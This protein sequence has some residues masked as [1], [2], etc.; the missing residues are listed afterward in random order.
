MGKNRRHNKS[1]NKLGKRSQKD[2]RGEW[3]E[4]ERE[5]EKWEN[6]YRNQNLIS[7]EEWPAFKKACQ[8]NLPLTFRI[9]GSNKHASEIGEIF[10]NKHIPVL[11]KIE[12]AEDYSPPKTFS[13]YPNN[14]GFQV[15]LPKSVVKKNVNFASTQRFLVSETEVGNISRQEAVSMIPPLVL[16]VEPHHFVLDMCAAP[17]SKTAQLVEA[18]HANDDKE[19]PT[20]FVMAN[21]S[22]YRRSHMLV[23]QIK[24]L[25]SP[26]FV[27]VNHDA[28][29]FPKIKL[30]KD[31]TEFV[32]FDRILCDVPCTGDATMRK[33]IN[34][35]KDWRIGNAIGLHPLQINILTRGLQLLKKGGRLVFSTCSLNPI[36]NEA[37]V[38]E[39]LRK[40]GGRIKTVNCDDRLPGLI[41]SHGVSNWKVYGKD[42]TIR[43]SYNEENSDVHKTC[44]PPTEE[45]A[46]EF[47]LENCMRVY[48]HT[49]NTGG[50]FITV[51]EKIDDS[52]VSNKRVNEETEGETTEVKKQKIENGV[53]ETATA[54]ETA[55]A[56]EAIPATEAAPAPAKP[57][58]KE[59]LP[60]D[61]IEEPFIFL[62]KDHTELSKCWDFYEFSDDF[63]KD[64]TLVRNA[65]GEP[66]RTIYYV[67]PV[68]KKLLTTNET[69]LKFVYSGVKLFHAQRTEYNKETCQ[70]RIQ[71]DS[72]HIIKNYISPKRQVSCNLDMLLILLQETFPK[73]SQVKED[74]IDT[75]FIEQ[76]SELS[77]GCCFLN[78][79]RGEN[80]EDLF[81]PLWKGK[82]NFNL[83]VNKHETFEL[84][85]RVFGIETSREEALKVTHPERENT[86]KVESSEAGEA[87]P[88][89][90]PIEEA[91][92]AETGVEAIEEAK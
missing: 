40:W 2:N 45:E 12:G 84:L 37:I 91:A 75:A 72:F 44:F 5:N 16:D 41:R 83:M 21:D 63:A 29:Q 60:R 80:K 55:A 48:P 53:G 92:P 4:I 89:E 26:N 85:Y 35:W 74:K 82:T 1:G 62:D 31:A 64:C 8:E 76:I 86:P 22:D 56:T 32:K 14:L 20:G 65:T 66:A 71:N 57:A 47:H 19:W 68:I 6:Y 58:K 25:N 28:Q 24:R 87:A 38:A 43:E 42:L 51:L 78:I 34:V 69:K 90:A 70:W 50:F 81:L 52:K 7:D 46:K 67:A 61:A 36:E 73:I 88:V 23:H 17:G 27:V 9:T 18:L 11:A 49:Q 30:S 15:D 79:E 54:T 33:N 39:V 59:R 3:K 10:R 77:E 13:W